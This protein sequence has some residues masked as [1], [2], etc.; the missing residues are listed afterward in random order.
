[1]YTHTPTHTHTHTLE[2]QQE[3]GWVRWGGAVRRAL[4]HVGRADVVGV[5]PRGYILGIEICIALMSRRE[6]C[7]TFHTASVFVINEILLIVFDID[8]INIAQASAI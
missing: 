6:S 8:K 1:M 4:S 3:C 2:G 7:K 5:R